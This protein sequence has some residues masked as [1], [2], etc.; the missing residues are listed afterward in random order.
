M[1]DN[2]DTEF[3]RDFSEDTVESEN[4]NQEENINSESS[5]QIDP[6]AEANESLITMDSAPF[7][8]SLENISQTLASID[9]KMDLDSEQ[10]KKLD[11]LDQLTEIKEQLDRIEN[12]GTIKS[13][14]N[15]NNFEDTN[16]NEYSTEEPM[17]DNISEINQENLEQENINNIGHN[18]QEI[19]ELYEKIEDLKQKLS[20]IEDQSNKQNEKITLH[21]RIR[22]IF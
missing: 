4:L 3:E 16:T 17:D 10:L 15:E 13:D 9:S 7:D 22:I 8:K 5:D 18:Q 6:I 2:N 20:T 21:I 19:S 1:S 12:T 11:Q 14:Y